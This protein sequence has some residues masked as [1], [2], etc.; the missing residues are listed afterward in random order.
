M[1]IFGSTY[2][3]GSV[4]PLFGL[5]P[6]VSHFKLWFYKGSTDTFIRF[7]SKLID[8]HR[9]GLNQQPSQNPYIQ[10]MSSGNFD[11]KAFVDPDDPSVI[12]IWNYVVYWSWGDS[13]GVSG[14]HTRVPHVSQS[15]VQHHH[16]LQPD[17]AAS[18]RE[19]AVLERADVVA[20]GVGVDA[21]L[22]CSL[23]QDYWVVDT[24]GA[25]CDL[26]PPHEEVVGAGEVRVVG[27]GHR[28]ER[29]RLLRV[30]VQHVEVRVVFLAN[31]D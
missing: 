2:L 25:R 23:L 27:A 9:K 29:S 10:Q 17:A 18:V 6:G 7:L 28:V 12:C 31:Y 19:G 1:P 14:E 13:L 5:L 3:K 16:P 22:L 21:A 30:S 8:A 26:L 4:K 20:D 11:R 15:A 24:L